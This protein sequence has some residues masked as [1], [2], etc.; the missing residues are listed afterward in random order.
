MK[1]CYPVRTDTAPGGS[2]YRT[3]LIH[4]R[5]GCASYFPKGGQLGCV[6]CDRSVLSLCFFFFFGRDLEIKLGSVKLLNFFVLFYFNK[7]KVFGYI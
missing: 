3:G 2:F 6:S 1:L 4:L 5:F 7:N